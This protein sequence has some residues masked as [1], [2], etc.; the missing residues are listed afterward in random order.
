MENFCKGMTIGLVAGMVIG[1]A[2]VASNKKLATKVRSILTGASEKFE[3]AKEML[4]EKIEES[5][6]ESSEQQQE[7]S[8]S[9]SSKK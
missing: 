1:G 7:P 9:K 8:Q 4:E 3:E 6:Q 2:I 5:K